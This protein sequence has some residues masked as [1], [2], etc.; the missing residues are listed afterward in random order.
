VQSML[1]ALRV[2]CAYSQ[3]GCTWI[4]A[5]SDFDVHAESCEYW[6][7]AL[8][9][10]LVVQIEKAGEEFVIP[11]KLATIVSISI[12]WGD[13]SQRSILQDGK[14]ARHIYSAA[15][16]YTIRVFP[17]GASANGCW[18]N[19]LGQHDSYNQADWEDW[20]RS[21]VE[22][23]QLGKLGITSLA[24]LFAGC[25]TF[26][27]SI[28]HLDVSAIADM[29]QM[30]EGAS[31]FNQPIAEWNVSKVTSTMEMFHGANSFNQPIGNW[32]V[33][34]VTD[35][36][37]MFNSAQ[38]F[39]Q[40]IGNWN[41]SNVTNMAGMFRF[42]SSFNQRIEEWDVSKVTNMSD[43]FHSARSF[44]QPIG[45]WNIS[46]VTIL[47]NMFNSASSFNQPIGDWN[48]SSVTDMSG[49]F[50]AAKSFNQPIGNWNVSNVTHMYCM[51][52][53]AS[54][55][56]QPIG[57]WN[58]G[59]VMDMR[60]MFLD[61]PFDQYLATLDLNKLSKESWSQMYRTDPSWTLKVISKLQA[62]LIHLRCKWPIKIVPQV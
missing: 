55:F 33:S 37:N 29:R 34:K 10:K 36:S 31:M 40:P 42:S 21:L 38:S 17:H 14:E 59:Q 61:C 3:D 47:S 52:H 1:N 19:H 51:F 39:N 7:P 56:N 49:M 54:S 30:F 32:D 20:A 43:M 50:L 28:Q 11:F 4:G 27:L 8:P 62:E 53:R 16:K 57:D 15:G 48:V 24:C 12:D 44:N 46:S 18:L 26:N 35:I 13:N 9:L 58:V 25:K 5:R 41:V 22:F 45:L 2:R 6:D 23:S 60:Y